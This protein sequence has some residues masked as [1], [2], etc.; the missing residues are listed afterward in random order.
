MLKILSLSIVLMLS[1]VALAVADCHE[2]GTGG[3]TGSAAGKSLEGKRY[4][5][6]GNYQGKTDSKGRVYDSKGIYQ[7]KV[8]KDGKIYSRSGR[9]LGKVQK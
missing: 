6:Q 9:Y 5:A 2:Q 8:T 1:G 7:G 3:L 4:N